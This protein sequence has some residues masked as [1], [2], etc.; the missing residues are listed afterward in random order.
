MV[1]V[2]TYLL[3][4]ALILRF[5]HQAH[6]KLGVMLVAL[7]IASYGVG[8]ALANQDPYAGG[9]QAWFVMILLFCAWPLIAT[10]ILFTLWP[11]R[12]IFSI[13]AYTIA[14]MIIGTISV[15]SVIGYG[16]R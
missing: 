5:V 11:R 3:P 7:G 13:V 4:L 8:V 16:A 1:P 2:F 10:G 6:I 14:S 12:R 15:L 9:A